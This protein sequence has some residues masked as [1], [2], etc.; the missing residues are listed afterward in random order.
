MSVLEAPFIMA[1]SEMLKNTYSQ[2]LNCELVTA[3]G[4]T[5]PISIAYC[6]SYAGN[7][8][9]KKPER[10]VVHCSGNI[11][12]NVKSVVVPQTGGL[13]G[14]EAAAAAGI[15]A[16]APELQLEVL[17]A[18]TEDKRKEL[19]QLLDL[20]IIDV[21]PLDSGHALHIIVELFAQGDSVSV[22]V[23]DGHT[24][25][26]KVV[27]NGSVLHENKLEAQNSSEID[28]SLLTVE[29]ILKYADSVDLEDVRE[30]LE[31]QISYNSAISREGLEHVYGA[32]IGPTLMESAGNSLREQCKAAAAAG[33][34]ARMNGCS[35]PVVINS[36]SGNQ[37]LTVSLPIIVWAKNMGCSH[38][39]LL[40]ALC[41]S[42]L[43]AVRQK[44]KIG[45][46]SAFCGATSAAVGAVCGI[47]YLDKAEASVIS[48]TIINSLA[49]IGG[50][51]CDGAKS[52]CA[53]KIASAI[54][55]AFTGYEA[56]K[57]HRGYLN[58]EGL[59]KVG[60]EETIDSVARM[61]AR[62]MHGTDLEILDIMLDK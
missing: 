37:G 38:E 12:K 14:I 47:A 21:R 19:R 57:K 33:S 28:Y 41:V 58:G 45:R 32:G 34:D 39:E 46:L 4:C 15:V 11:I 25:I 27:K 23:V 17:T 36:G 6:A 3:M 29:G 5:E 48:Q 62:G 44:T 49:T 20:G 7:L 24:N 51:V 35:L 60:V 42:N 56:A 59:V 52:S 2:I 43:I 9:G 18:L 54:D 50:M 26:G 55:C 53:G 22:E 8:L 10:C 31:R 1:L 30:V 40:R 61:A 16:L 13:K